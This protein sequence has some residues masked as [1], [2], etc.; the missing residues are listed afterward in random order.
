MYLVAFLDFG[1]FLG[2]LLRLFRE[3]RCYSVRGRE[4]G[5][6]REKGG[7]EREKRG[8]Q[9]EE[10]GGSLAALPFLHLLLTC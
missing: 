8:E 1:G 6:D 5:C 4:R 3:W 10:D 7:R 2:A 9:K